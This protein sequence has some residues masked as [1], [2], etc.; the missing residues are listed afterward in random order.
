MRGGCRCGRTTLEAAGE[1]FQ[2]SYCHCDDC[3]RA[4]GAPVTLFVGFAS[5]AVRF[6]GEA[7]A[8][9]SQVEGVE[10]LFC[11]VCGTPLAYVDRRLEDETYLMAGALDE[12][13][14]LRPQRHAFEAERLSWFDVADD[15]PREDGYTRPR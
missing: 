2:V 3:R 13:R 1:P 6:G 7:P 10:R 8:R 9:W 14:A 12:V 4:S 11:P 5:G 15:L